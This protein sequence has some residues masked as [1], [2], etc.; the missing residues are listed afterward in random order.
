M[1][2][3]ERERERSQLVIQPVCMP[4]G[5]L[6][7]PTHPY[8][9]NCWVTAGWREHRFVWIPKEEQ[10]EADQVWL[11]LSIDDFKPEIMV[12]TE[13]GVHELYRC[14]PPWR[15]DYFFKVG[16]KERCVALDQKRVLETPNSSFAGL[17]AL[18]VAKTKWMEKGRLAM[19]NFLP[20]E[21]KPR[22]GPMKIMFAWPRVP[23]GKAMTPHRPRSA[24]SLPK[25]VFTNYKIH[26][27]RG[28]AKSMKAAF[29]DGKQG[30]RAQSKYFCFLLTFSTNHSCR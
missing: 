30:C 29:Q 13:S 2:R 25:S 21:T 11:C 17:A 26:N 16:E 3:R 8:Q 1:T 22:K 27:R 12:K 10:D 19:M 7:P 14:V 24:W 20:R 28:R 5:L 9:A 15:V 18:A 23:P 4:N 6:G